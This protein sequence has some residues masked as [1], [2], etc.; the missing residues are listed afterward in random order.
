MRLFVGIP[1]AT[2]AVS[3][4]S[5]ILMRLRSRDDGLRWSASES[6]HI[7]LQFLGSTSQE[8]YACIVAQL[9]ELR[10]PPVSIQLDSLGLFDRAGIFFADA[11]PTPELAM[12]Q[13]RVSAATTPCGFS[14]ETRSFH[15]HITL[16]R[17]K[18]KE[19]KRGLQRL[20]A[21]SFSPHF[22]S[23]M[24]EY[25]FLYESFTGPSGSHYEIRDRFRLQQH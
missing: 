5:A 25:F 19:G 17:S 7:T 11:R 18:G 2:T 12:L 6:W 14:A 8:Q 10:S 15:P 9:H 24:A 21:S 1:L 16:A 4:L 3:E 22:S 20:Q 23:F 13:H